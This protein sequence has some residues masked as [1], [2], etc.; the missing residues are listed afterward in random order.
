M[1]Y[2]II[3][4]ILFVNMA[5]AQR[6]TPVVIER[7]NSTWGIQVGVH[8]FTPIIVDF[9]INDQA[10]I[11]QINELDIWSDWQ[12][13]TD[14]GAMIPNFTDSDYD[15]RSFRFGPEFSSDVEVVVRRTRM[16]VVRGASDGSVPSGLSQGNASI[17]NEGF[18]SSSNCTDASSEAAYE[19]YF[20]TLPENSVF[21]GGRIGKFYDFEGTDF[22]IQQTSG[23]FIVASTTNGTE[24]GSDGMTHR[25]RCAEDAYDRILELIVC[26][27]TCATRNQ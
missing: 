22:Y 9:R 27:D 3:I 8:E 7:G 5:Q 16:V 25:Y 23:W 26:N 21:D 1:K 24:Y 15:A 10:F 14:A 6:I 13:I 11:Q 19:M 20:A 2:I 17:T 4:A 12:Y 18:V